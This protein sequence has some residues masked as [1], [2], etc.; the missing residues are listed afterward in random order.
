MRSGQRQ[1]PML[2]ATVMWKKICGIRDAGNSR[3]SLRLDS[4]LVASLHLA[5]LRRRAA[6]RSGFLH[7]GAARVGRIDRSI[8]E[9]T[10]QVHASLHACH[11]RIANSYLSK[12][13]Q[14]RRADA[15][16]VTQFTGWLC[17]TRDG[18]GFGS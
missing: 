16:K 9:V 18:E 5:P 13:L 1:A 15:R 7:F 3:C 2:D 10:S 4:G 14:C 17:R 8:R 12:S 11:H 6:Q